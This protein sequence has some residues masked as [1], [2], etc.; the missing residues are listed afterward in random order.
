MPFKSKNFYH[1]RTFRKCKYCDKEAKRNI[2]KG[3]NKGY[4]RTCGAKECV[5]KNWKLP[6]VIN[7]KRFVGSTHP[8]WIADRTKI[9][10]RS[11][12]ENY[13]WKKAVFIRDDYTCQSC[14]IRGGGLQADHIKPYSLFPE[15]RWNLDNGRTL[16]VPCHKLT[17]TYA[18]TFKR[19][20]EYYNA[21][22]KS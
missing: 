15:E 4:Y 11:R 7:K 16:C 17:P 12:Y 10:T 18:R 5:Q 1:T 13:E 2:Y 22:Q 19:K 9:K 20:E 3:R 6:E 21:I 14:G 8:R